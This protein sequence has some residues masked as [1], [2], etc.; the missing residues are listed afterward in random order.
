MESVRHSHSIVEYGSF[1]FHPLHVPN[2]EKKT[3]N[4]NFARTPI[5]KSQKCPELVFDSEIQWGMDRYEPWGEFESIKY[6]EI[7]W[8]T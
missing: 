6:P 7:H 8:K 1:S 4:R 3:Q 2:S 5:L